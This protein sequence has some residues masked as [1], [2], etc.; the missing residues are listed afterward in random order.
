MWAGSKCHTAAALPKGERP[1]PLYRRLSG[2][3]GCSGR[4]WKIVFPPGFTP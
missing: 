2:P 1:G 4:V 3:Q